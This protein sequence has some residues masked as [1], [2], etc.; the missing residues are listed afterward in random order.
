[1]TGVQTC[2]LPISTKVACNPAPI[3][4]SRLESQGT[5]TN[6]SVKDAETQMFLA[7]PMKERGTQASVDV[8]DK[9]SQTSGTS[10][11]DELPPFVYID[12]A[13]DT[14]VRLF[15]S[16]SPHRRPQVRDVFSLRCLNFYAPFFSS[17]FLV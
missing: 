6:V 16:F 9:E 12:V 13:E 15:I 4:P 5:Q 8:E 10:L 17:E 14:W 1:M 7:M 2:A 11:H 3:S